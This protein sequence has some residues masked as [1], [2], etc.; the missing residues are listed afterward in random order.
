M[1]RRGTYVP[2]ATRREHIAAALGVVVGMLAAGEAVAVL[3]W[4][5]Q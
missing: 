1:N 3:L 5:A 2:P 4:L